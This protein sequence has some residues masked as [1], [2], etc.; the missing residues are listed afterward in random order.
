MPQHKGVE[1]FMFI[2]VIQVTVTY[3]GTGSQHYDC[4][5]SRVVFFGDQQTHDDFLTFVNGQKSG[6]TRI[7]R[8]VHDYQRQKWFNDKLWILA[9]LQNVYINGNFNPAIL[10]IV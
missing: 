1:P 2:W 10:P 5:D 4:V 7:I 9:T 3:K 8:V 6:G